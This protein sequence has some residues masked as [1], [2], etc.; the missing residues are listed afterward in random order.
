M[1][2]TLH[3]TAEAV[4]QQAIDDM[5]DGARLYKLWSRLAFH[6][7]R[8][9]FRRSMLGP[10]WLTLSMGILIES[11]GSRVLDN[12]PTR[13]STD[14]ALH[15][16][17]RHFL[18]PACKLLEQEHLNVHLGAISHPQRANADQRVGP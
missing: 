11:N 7:I 12:I 15:R 1:N 18:G 10:F 8:Q 3:I 9:R 13:C 2:V 17:G 14:A 6:N 4:P 16:N 5:V